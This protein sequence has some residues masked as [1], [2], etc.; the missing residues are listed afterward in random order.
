MRKACDECFDI[1]LGTDKADLFGD[2]LL[3]ARRSPQAPR[4]QG[5]REH[6]AARMTAVCIR[7]NVMMKVRERLQIRLGQ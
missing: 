7:G 1:S 3:E 4:Q 2:R 6:V 5:A